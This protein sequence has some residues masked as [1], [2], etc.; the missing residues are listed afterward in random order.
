LQEIQQVATRPWI[1]VKYVGQDTLDWAFWYDD[2]A[3]DF[4]WGDILYLSTVA[5]YGV[6]PSKIY[7][8]YTGTNKTIIDDNRYLS[9]NNS[10][11][12]IYQDVSWQQITVSPV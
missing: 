9:L 7:D 2:P 11:Y 3:H 5:F 4:Q 12:N 8:S 10:E 6:N 1:N